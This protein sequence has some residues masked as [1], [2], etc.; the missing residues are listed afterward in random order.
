ME[1]RMGDLKWRMKEYRVMLLLLIPVFY[2]TALFFMAKKTKQRAYMKLGLFFGAV[3]V[4][5]FVIGLM[6]LVFRPLFYALIL[7]LGCWAMCAMQTLYIRQRYLQLREWELEDADEQKDPL[8]CQKGWRL[9]NALWCIWDCI[10]LLGGLATYFMGRRMDS[11]KLQWIGIGSTVLMAVL[12]VAI[13]FV[14][15]MDSTAAK[16]LIV[17]A[18]VLGYSCICIHPLLAGYY[19]QEYLNATAEMWHEDLS[20]Y[21]LMEKTG[22]RIKNSLWQIITCI[23][24]L[25]TFGLFFVGIHRQNGKVLLGAS[26][27]CVAEMACLSVPSFLVADEAQLKAWPMLEG[28]AATIGMLWIL[29]YALIVFYGA[30]I[31]WDML[32]ERAWMLEEQE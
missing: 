22:W 13:S 27:L 16:V 31:R 14:P 26:L 2:F 28:V 4:L 12:F 18:I 9:S 6:G 17:A 10:P 11:K 24:Y 20:D 30:V 32:R 1:K 8:L 29:V 3:S 15:I 25:G 21:P 5:S 23:P 19:F 7:Q